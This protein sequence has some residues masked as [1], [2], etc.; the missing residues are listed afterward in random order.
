MQLFLYDTITKKHTQIT[1]DAG[2]KEEPSWSPCGNYLLFSREKNSKSRL[3]ILNV[4]TNERRFITPPN[5][6]VSYPAWSG[7]YER[8]PHFSCFQSAD[9]VG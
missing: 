8:V 3:A 1:G 4:L 2:N 6:H 7:R 5:Q 9:S